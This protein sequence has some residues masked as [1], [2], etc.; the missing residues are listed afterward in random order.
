MDDPSHIEV[1]AFTHK[2]CVRA[3]NED[4]IVVAGWISELEMSAPRRWRHALGEP[5]L[6]AVADGLGGHAAGNVA[7]RLV[8]KR[9]AAGKASAQADGIAAR[10]AGINTELYETMNSDPSLVGMGTTIA[11]LVLCSRRAVWF[12]VGDSR[13]YRER[14][15]RIEQLSVD[16]VPPGPRNGVITQTLGGCRSF[17]PISPHIGGEEFAGNLPHASRWLLCSDGLTDMLDDAEIERAFAASDE[18]T[19]W[20]LFAAAMAAG[21]RDNISIVMVSAGAP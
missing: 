7:S 1:T 17:I 8:T 21:G 6:V 18:E 11:G 20:A 15:G 16:D 5:L 12:N 14:G 10:L 4:S 13:I 9:L 3:R 19:L 2:G